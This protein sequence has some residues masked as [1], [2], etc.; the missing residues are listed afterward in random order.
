VVKNYLELTSTP[1]VRNYT[2]SLLLQ[3]LAWILKILWLQDHWSLKL[4]TNKF[5][6]RCLNLNAETKEIWKKIKQHDIPKG[7]QPHTV[8][9]TKDSEKEESPKNSRAWSKKWSMNLKST[10]IKKINEFKENANK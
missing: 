6:L 2:I 8:T 10:C 9:D 1:V 4:P 5:G 3:S 7:R